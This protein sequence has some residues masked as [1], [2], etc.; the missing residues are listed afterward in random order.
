MITGEG[1][2]GLGSIFEP[3]SE[4]WTHPVGRLR[5]SIAAVS[6]AKVGLAS[7]FRLGA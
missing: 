3:M 7:T 2:V 4:W 6:A 5:C 1:S